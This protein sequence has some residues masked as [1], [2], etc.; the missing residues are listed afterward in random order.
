M[1]LITIL[2]LHSNDAGILIKMIFA[3]PAVLFPL[4]A[5]FI[6]LDTGR[7]KTYLPL[8]AA[9]KCIGIFIL[10]GWSIISQQVTMIS[11]FSSAAIIAGN[12][13]ANA[14]LI[15]LSGDFFA[16]AAVILIIARNCAAGNV[17]KPA[18]AQESLEEK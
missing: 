16:L 5:L 11:S 3:A 2:I 9:G 12:F 4:M 17:Q 8:F 18:S 10:L 14:G 1:I 13:V 6:W 7:Y 15:L